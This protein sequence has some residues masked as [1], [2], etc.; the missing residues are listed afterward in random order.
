MNEKY[1]EKGLKNSTGGKQSDRIC[2]RL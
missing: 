2:L 1:A